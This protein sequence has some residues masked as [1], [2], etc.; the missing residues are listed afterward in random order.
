MKFGIFVL[1]YNPEVE[2]VVRRLSN[3]NKIF[4]TMLIVDNSQDKPDERMAEILKKV[5]YHAMGENKGISKALEYAFEW[6]EKEKIDYLLTMDQD[7]EYP[8]QEIEK[9]IDFIENT[10]N[11]KVGIYAANYRKLYF[12]NIKG[13]MTA[14]KLAIEREDVKTVKACMTSGSFV[15]VKAV[16]KALPLDDYFVAYVDIDLSAW[17]LRNGYELKLVGN[18]VFEQ[19]VGN[20]VTASKYNIFFR[21]LHHTEKRYYFITRNNFYFRNKYKEHSV[22]ALKRLIRVYINILLGEE[23]KIAKAKSGYLG[24]LHYKQGIMGDFSNKKEK[25]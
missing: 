20:P 12:D 18:S 4:D 23:N 13:V 21:I 2:Q 24:Y 5:D 19:Q 15:N 25:E 16:Q 7:S 6:A 1:L 17:F 14:G 10:A 8:K 3:Y 11:E 22:F 9:M